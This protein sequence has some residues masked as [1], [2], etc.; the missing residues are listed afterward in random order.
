MNGDNHV[1]HDS[2]PVHRSPH[3]RPRRRR[4]TRHTGVAQAAP[5]CSPSVGCSNGET[6]FEKGP[7]TPDGYGEDIVKCV[8]NTALAAALGARW[9]TRG[10][11]GGWV[12]WN[13]C[14]DLAG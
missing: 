10:T 4:R 12:A 11:L 2:N 7:D 1:P 8:G 14:G 3:H 5:Y 13:S 9:L 6:I